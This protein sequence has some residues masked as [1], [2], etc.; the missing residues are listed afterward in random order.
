MY[1]YNVCTDVIIYVL[2]MLACIMYVHVHV[3][4]VGPMYECNNMYVLC[5][6]ACIM[7]VVVDCKP[8]HV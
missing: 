6:H 5:M 8:M 3:C 7:Y 2:C 4:N 1:M